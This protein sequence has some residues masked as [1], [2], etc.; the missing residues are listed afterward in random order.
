MSIN[1]NRTRG[2]SITLNHDPDNKEVYT[3]WYRPEVWSPNKEVIQDDAILRPTVANG[4]MYAVSQGG[5]TGVTEPVW[6][7]AQNSIVIS[8][9]AKLKALPY[10]LLL[11]SGDIIEA[12]VSNSVPAYE[13]ILPVGVTIDNDILTNGSVIHF[14][15]TSV[16][17]VGLYS[18]VCRVSVKKAGGVYTRYDD[19]INLNVVNS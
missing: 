11:K 18:L 3:L 12:D 9:S 17:G 13:F 8:G 7:T 16:P 19:T 15:V 4:C 2:K 1:Y 10:A 14:R 5:L 6:T